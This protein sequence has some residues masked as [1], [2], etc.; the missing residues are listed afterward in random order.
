MRTLRPWRSLVAAGLAGL[1]F[2][3]AS[4][5]EP[6]RAAYPPHDDTV[7]LRIDAPDGV[8]TELGLVTP[9][10][11]RVETAAEVNETG[12]IYLP[13]PGPGE[14]EPAAA[15]LFI[16]FHDAPSGDGWE[17]VLTFP[18]DP[19]GTWTL[20]AIE[21]RVDGALAREVRIPTTVL[22]RG[23]NLFLWRGEDRRLPALSYRRAVRPAETRVA[24][25]VPAGDWQG[26]FTLR[27]RDPAGREAAALGAAMVRG[28]EPRRKAVDPGVQPWTD[29]ARLNEAALA[30]GRH[31]LHSR[32]RDAHSRFYDGFHLVYDVPRE[33]SRISHWL[34]AWGP[35]IHLLFALE[36]HAVACG[37]PEWGAR[38][39]RAAIAAARRSLAF[40]ATEPDHPARGVSRVRWEISRATPD[41]WIEYLSTA[42]SLFLA[43]WGWMSAYAETGD[44]AFLG[45]TRTLV[46]A[47]QRLMAEYPVV[48]QDWIT[49][50]NRWTPH[51]LDESVFGMIGFREL[52]AAT[53]DPGVAQAGRAFLDSHLRHMGR[54]SG[55]LERAWMR[56]ADEAIWDPDIKG[57]AWVVEGYLDAHR[58][59][60]DPRYLALARELAAKVMASQR[61]DGSW[62]YVFTP[63]SL[64]EPADDKGTAIWAYCF[65]VLHDATRDP[66]H[67]AAARAALAWCLRQQ[68]RGEDDRLDGGLLHENG[69]A[70]VKRRP[71]TILYSTTFF[72]LALLEELKQTG[73]ARGGAR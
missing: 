68:Y 45:R 36:E 41:G 18:G 15:E 23:E 10:V 73:G 33:A 32:V 54:E 31:L 39:R 40:G 72:G 16:F 71:M 5:E 42:D 21:A 62:S 66:A 24:V 59:S 60:G 61:E 48:P 53:G 52:H 50:R 2:A 51:T 46:D 11:G 29:R 38:F 9:G 64:D 12:P 25:G 58:L 7:E 69:M 37:E 4:A 19:T 34:W 55:L 44:T 56:E 26:E 65:Y 49:E 20:N 67:L 27:R 1:L 3:R 8:A 28:R 17:L 14:P 13:P 57:H 47:A 43:G 70:Y 35:A 63:P 30:V 22:L 6:L